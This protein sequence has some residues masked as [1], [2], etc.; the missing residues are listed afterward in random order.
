MTR[1]QDLRPRA[2]GNEQ[3]AGILILLQTMRTI[4]P[5]RRLPLR[6]GL[7]CFQINRGREVLV[8]V[9]HVQPVALCI[10]C[11]AFGPAFKCQFFFLVQSLAVQNTNRVVAWRGN[12][13]FFCGRYIDDAVGRRID[14]ATGLAREGLFINGADTGVCPVTDVHHAVADRYAAGA[15]RVFRSRCQHIPTALQSNGDRR[16]AGITGL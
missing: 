13:D 1:V 5:T 16:G 6:H 8:L 7:V 11:I 2:A 14:V 9:I 12:P 4:L 3:V 15:L 10:D